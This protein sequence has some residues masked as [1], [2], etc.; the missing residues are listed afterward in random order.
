MQKIVDLWPMR[1]LLQQPSVIFLYKPKSLAGP[2][3][4][5]KDAKVGG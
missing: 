4:G 1:F 5:L 2:S 3:I